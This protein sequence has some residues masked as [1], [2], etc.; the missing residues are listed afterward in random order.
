MNGWTRVPNTSL[1]KLINPRNQKW[2][3]VWWR[4]QSLASGR[5]Q[6][7]G[8]KGTTPWSVWLL[9]TR[10]LCE[11]VCRAPRARGKQTA[12]LSLG[13]ERLSQKSPEFKYS[14]VS[15]HLLSLC[16]YGAFKDQAAKRGAVTLPVYIILRHQHDCSTSQLPVNVT[17]ELNP[18]SVWKR[19]RE[20][21]VL[22]NYAEAVA[23]LLKGKAVTAKVIVYFSAPFFVGVSCKALKT[24]KITTVS[25]VSIVTPDN[26][27]RRVQWRS[28]ILQTQN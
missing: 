27:R 5:G 4:V 7:E 18:Q 14:A 23:R 22:L 2:N 25:A 19:L 13:H 26:E 8:N 3:K 9:I 20:H 11:W 15:M 6:Q 28:E 10:K 17:P 1:G 16:L 21:L 24:V 12:F